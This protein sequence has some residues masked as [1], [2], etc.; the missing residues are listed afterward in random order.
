M[1]FAKALPKIDFDHVQ[2]I[3][4][5]TIIPVVLILFAGAGALWMY[6]FVFSLLPEGQSLVE[7]PGL[8]SNVTVLRDGNGIPGII[9]ETEDDVVL[10]LGYV[11]AQDRLWQM[12]YL[13]R[14]GQGRLSEILGPNYLEGDHLMR[15][16]K[17]GRRGQDVPVKLG[18]AENRWLDKFVQGINKYISAHEG[19]LPVEFSLLEYSPAIFS[20]DDVLTILDSLAWETSIAARVDPVMTRVLGRLAKNRALQLFPTDPAVSSAEVASD[21]YGWE[22]KG[23][24]FSA[25]GMGRT[26]TRVPGLN[27][28]CGWAVS[29]SRSRSAKALTGCCFYQTL[30][31]PGFWY[32]A[33]LFAKNFQLSGVFI[34][35]VPI[36]MAGSNPRLS[37]GCI[38]CPVD[39]ADLYIERLDS[40]DAK[41][42]FRVDRWIKMEEVNERYRVKG[43]GSV[44]RSILMTDLGPIVSDVNRARALSLRWT[45]QERL[46]LFPAI[47]NLNRATN[48]NQLQ[49]ALKGLIAPCLNVL[50]ADDEANLGIQC[51]GRIPIRPPAS[52]GIVPMPAWT[53]T[54]KWVGF[55]PFHE[56]PS[57]TN[58]GTGLAVVADGRPGGPEYP[59]FVSC[60]WNDDYKHRR[61]RE[62]LEEASEHDLESFYKIQNDTFSPMAASLVPVV[63][64][65]WEKHGNADSGEREAVRILNTWDFQMNRESTGAA[66]FGLV[67]QSLVED[68]LIKSL[69]NELFSGFTSYPPLAARLVRNVFVDHRSEWLGKTDRAAFLVDSFQKAIVRGKALMGNS[70]TKWKWGEIHTTVFRHPVSAKSRFLEALYQV[71]PLATS[72]S[73][74]TINSSG[75]SVAHP[76][77]VAGGVSF[78]QFA[79]MSQ[80]P[81]VFG[82]IP[83]G[84]SA[85]FFSAYYKDQTS[86]WLTGRALIDPLNMADI[87]KDGSN[88]VLFRPPAIGS[89]SL[90]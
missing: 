2:L 11:M 61:I 13:R 14:A 7:T 77:G 75:W 85:H 67:Y 82:V 63:V 89:I 79:D 31:A 45:G 9:G 49:G 18:D 33:R 86:A 28:G 56:L 6:L 69:G 24:L 90:K 22:P 81:L 48:G 57:Q 43:G 32:R 27:G 68:L 47:F 38:S 65:A 59:F 23:A 73:S 4:I 80:P 36:A 46:G 39:D 54:Y 76:F 21:L 29:Q 41:S 60:Y 72:G 1:N 52:D 62:L 10:V 58:P 83:L 44:S 40:D 70:I 17:A 74:D 16:I 5:F 3:R 34:P 30:T 15:T 88:S 26:L 53:E 20:R 50:W 37:W 78:R 42:Y 35:G 64:D 25:L 19:K 66:I 55:I 12:D 87:S 71:G 51:A 8:T 84:S